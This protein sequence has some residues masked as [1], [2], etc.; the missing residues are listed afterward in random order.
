MLASDLRQGAFVA[1][2]FISTPEACVHALLTFPLAA[3]MLV[4]DFDF[5]FHFLGDD[6]HR[7]C[8]KY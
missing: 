1:L 5:I 7:L 6:E 2:A 8:N 3:K 4:V